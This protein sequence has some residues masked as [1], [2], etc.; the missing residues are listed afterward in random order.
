MFALAKAQVFLSFWH[1]SLFFSYF[2]SLN[3]WVF[4]GL[5]SLKNVL[6]FWCFKAIFS[7]FF[8]YFTDIYYPGLEN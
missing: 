3:S 4:R 6:T 8:K 5:F 1:L 7:Y 2:I